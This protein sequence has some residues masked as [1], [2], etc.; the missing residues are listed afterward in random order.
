VDPLVV[1]GHLGERVD[2]VLGDGAPGGDAEFLADVF[3]ELVDPVED[4]HAFGPPAT[5]STWP[6]TNP[7]FSEA[8]KD[9]ALAMSAGLP[10]RRTGI[11]AAALVVNSSKVM[12]NRSA[13]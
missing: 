9:T 2:V 12:P 10:V 11:A 3:F 6:E 7:A 5:Y 13:V 4:L 1:V 8:K